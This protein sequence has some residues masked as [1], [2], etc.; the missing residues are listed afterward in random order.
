MMGIVMTAI[1]M[2]I[3]TMNNLSEVDLPTAKLCTSFRSL[4]N[5]GRTLMYVV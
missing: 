5:R 4:V 3:L 2:T 1:Y